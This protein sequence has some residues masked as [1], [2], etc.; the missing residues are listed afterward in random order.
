MKFAD[1]PQA[2]IDENVDYTVHEIT[3]VI[4]KYGPRES[5]NENCFAAQKHIKKELDTFCDETSF[6][7]YKMSPKAFLQWTKLVS[8]AIFL[9]VVICGALALSSVITM[10]LAQCIVCGVV[11]VSLFITVMEFLL[12]KQFMDVFYKKVEGHNLLGVRKPSGEVKRRI[13]I[14][15]HIDSAYEW[16]HIYYGKNSPLMLTLMGGTIGGAVISFVL[17]VI[18]IVANFVDMGAFGSFMNDYS[19]FF[20]FFTALMMVT[21]FL[22]V[23]FKTISPGANDNLTGTYAAVSALRMLDMAGVDFENT[24]VCAMITDGEEAGL[25]GCKQWAKDHYDEYVNSGVETAVLCVDTLTDLEYLNV[26]QRDMT[27]TVQHSKEFSQLVMD[28]AIEAGH[29]DLKFANVFFGSSD[30]AAFTQAG[31]TA[32]CLAAMDPAPADYYHNRRDSYDRL[33]PEAIKTGYEVILSTIFNF[34]EKGLG[35]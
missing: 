27:G 28:S 34:D 16:R 35:K 29:N 19:F 3:N 17:S 7:S 21:L 4:K 14:S 11:A 10:F 18:A 33:V 20:H 22:F 2:V 30:A 5:G 23:D 24:E 32:T 13:I 9:S 15:G 1:F 31:I 12:Y 6:E 26:Y 8:A 25:R